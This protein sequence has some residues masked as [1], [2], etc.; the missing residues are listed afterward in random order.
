MADLAHVDDGTRDT[1]RGLGYNVSSRFMPWNV[2]VE[3]G[4]GSLAALDPELKNGNPNISLSP[5]QRSLIPRTCIYQID[6]PCCS[7]RA[8]LRLGLPSGIRWAVHKWP[9]PLQ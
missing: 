2:W 4:N 6:D 9:R 3:F 5:E 7:R 8:G 1:L